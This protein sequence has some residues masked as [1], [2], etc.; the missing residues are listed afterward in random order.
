MEKKKGFNIQIN[1]SNRWLYTFIA[2]GIL[3]IIGVGVYAW[4]NPTTGVGHS[5]DE[6]E[7]CPDGQILQT[8]GG[9]WGCVN[10]S[11]G[12]GGVD[13]SEISGMP[14]G[15]ADGVDDTG[16][17][18]SCSASLTS[19]SLYQFISKSTIKTCPTNKPVMAGV[20]YDDYGH[21]IRGIKCC[22]ISI[23]CS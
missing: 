8:S 19:C 7:P 23:T 1:L 4:S 17:S 22:S 10:M 18:P 6:I 12:G 5:H 21:I 3:M 11:E 13:W 15:F 16:G 9:A 2:I 20:E 14:S